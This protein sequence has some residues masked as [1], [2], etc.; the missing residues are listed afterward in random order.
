MSK[1]SSNQLPKA[2][3]SIFTMESSPEILA[4]HY[5]GKSKVKTAATTGILGIICGSAS[6][7]SLFYVTTTH[8]NS[9][10]AYVCQN[11]FQFN[12][13][14]NNQINVIDISA[15]M[16]GNVKTGTIPTEIGLF[17]GLVSLNM[18][19]NA[20]TSTIPTE[21]GLLPKLAYLDLQGNQLTGTIPT[22]VGLLTALANI[23]LSFNKLSGEIP[24]EF[25]LINLSVLDI[26]SN[27]ITGTIPPELCLASAPRMT[28]V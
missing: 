2:K 26:N 14:A 21:I 7:K 27:Q 5:V 1:L 9:G 17:V 10:D 18:N 24:T 3:I 20:F 16:M 13:D 22:E 23:N 25:G 19:A 6:L 15:E 12:C 8:C 4:G 28:R 11:V